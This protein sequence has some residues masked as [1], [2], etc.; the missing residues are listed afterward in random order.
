MTFDRKST[1]GVDRSV[2]VDVWRE[3]CRHIEIQESTQTIARI[4][5]KLGPIRQLLVRSIDRSRN[6]LETVAN[7]IPD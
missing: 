5:A 1:A 3:A 2:L 4:L 7:R 6:C